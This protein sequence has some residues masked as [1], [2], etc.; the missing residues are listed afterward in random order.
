MFLKKLKPG[1]HKIWAREYKQ[2]KTLQQIAERYGVTKQGVHLNLQKQN[3]KM[4]KQKDYPRPEIFSD[5]EKKIWLERSQQG[6]NPNEISKMPEVTAGNGTIQ[7]YLQAQGIGFNKYLRT[8]TLSQRC[9][10]LRLEGLMWWQVADQITL[11]EGKPITLQAAYAYAAS[12]SA[13]RELLWPVEIPRKREIPKKIL[14]DWIQRYHQ[15]EPIQLIAG[16]Q[17]SHRFIQEKLVESGV[18]ITHP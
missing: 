15:G 1:A 8:N 6:F 16:S 5:E 18:T 11:E 2:G 3:V 9:Y 13:Y 12:H 10:E 17:Y 4:R 14:N 7:K